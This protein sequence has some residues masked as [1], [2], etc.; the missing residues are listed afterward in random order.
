MVVMKGAAQLKNNYHTILTD[1]KE[2]IFNKMT[3]LQQRNSKKSS[4]AITVI[5]PI[6]RKTNY[7]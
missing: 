6:N 7:P 3:L 4:F 1:D 5:N 2:M